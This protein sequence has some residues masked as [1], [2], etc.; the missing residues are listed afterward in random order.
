MQ[1]AMDASSGPPVLTEGQ[2]FS[3]HDLRAFYTTEHKRLHGELPDLHKN[4]DTTA[5]VYD[6]SREVKRR[7]L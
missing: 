6:R 1:A 7:S 4:R 5:R 3:F 2:R